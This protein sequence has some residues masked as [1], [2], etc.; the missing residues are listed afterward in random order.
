MTEA[1][2]AY[3]SHIRKK[4]YMYKKGETQKLEKIRAKNAKDYWKLLKGVSTAK[5]NANISNQ[6]FHMY[7]K[8][9]NNSSNASSRIDSDINNL[10]ERYIN[11]ELQVMFSELDIEI[12]Q[13]EIYKACK[14][15]RNN[16]S[17][18]PDCLI[19]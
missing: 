15:L 6:D 3:K 8:S 13:S 1:R 7:F 16:R 19:N 17:G 5:T 9:I 2:A 12:T 10:N 4:Q 14:E 18:G 11:D